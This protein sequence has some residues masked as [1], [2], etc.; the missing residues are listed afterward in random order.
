MRAAAVS[1]LEEQRAALR[2]GFDAEL[3]RAL[4]EQAMNPNSNPN[5]N[6]DQAMN[7]RHEARG[8]REK[9]MATLV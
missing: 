9:A 1:Q 6:P 3:K 7:L 8:E 2:R 5:P 4:E